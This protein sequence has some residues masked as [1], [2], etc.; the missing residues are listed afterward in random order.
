MPYCNNCGTQVSENAKFCENCGSTVNSYQYYSGQPQ[1]NYQYPPQ[2]Y[3][4]YPR[5]KT[6]GKGQGIASMV[7][8]IIGLVY[9]F[10]FFIAVVESGG[11]I[12]DMAAVVFIMSP[13][14]IMAICFANA[15]ANNGYICGISNAGRITGIIGLIGYIISFFASF[16]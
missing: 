3:S 16:S 10:L 14:S 1:Y 6:P 7:L 9:A 12:A 13:L 4:Y 5:P 2:Q 15:A 8:G 11:D